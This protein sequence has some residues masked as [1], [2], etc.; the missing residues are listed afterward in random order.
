MVV[1]TDV[2]YLRE[3]AGALSAGLISR[4]EEFVEEFPSGQASSAL[5]A[6]VKIFISQVDL[7]IRSTGELRLLRLYCYLLD[8]L[9]EVLEWLDHAHIAHTP[10][11]CVHVLNEM[12]ST[13]FSDSKILVTPTVESN[14]I[15]SNEV[16]R[17]EN[18]TNALPE[19]S[20]NLIL[21]RLPAYLYRVRFPRVEKEN[22]LNHALFGHEIGHP[23]ADEFFEKHEEG[24]QYQ[25]RLKSA[26]KEI[27][28]EPEI[29]DD[30]ANCA[31]STERAQL[32]NEIS[33][34]LSQI[35]KR[36]LVELVS[37]GVAVFVFGP[38]AIFSALDFFIRDQLDEI[39]SE[40]EYYPP[41]RY[42]WRHMLNVLASE[43]HV[44][45]LRSLGFTPGQSALRDSLESALSYLESSTARSTDRDVL[46]SD[47]YTRISYAW[48]EI[49]LPEALTYARSRV[50]SLLYSR[51]LIPQEVPALLE[52]LQA[53][54]PPCE[55]GTWPNV[56]PVN[57]RSALVASWILA[58]YQSL[59]KS[60]SPDLRKRAVQTTYS[61]A[62]KG[63][64]YIFLQKDYGTFAAET[65]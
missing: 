64:E 55:I 49:T 17:F 25:E 51:D 5:V 27:E 19:S 23:I 41:T 40:D 15:I 3:K 30:L 29:A 12:A 31:D 22:I 9:A 38:S 10:R 37:D 1:F 47:P 32:V 45:A 20:A 33:D 7:Q 48:L 2:D 56:R 53:S 52:R 13:L 43:G 28:N 60:L 42:R 18:L 4:L 14:Y 44:D 21:E 63:I 36:A 50:S 8:E 11:A 39:P 65:K 34:K 26:V 62:T 61:L 35:H 58:L 16:S 59:D 57:W 24:S 54:V 46:N 6:T